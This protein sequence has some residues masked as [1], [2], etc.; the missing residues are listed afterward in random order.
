MTDKQLRKAKELKKQI[1][2]CD[3]ILSFEVNK[4]VWLC[5]NEFSFMK[6]EI[7]DAVKN[8]KAELQAEFDNL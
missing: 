8:K 7:F 5:D 1:Q 3:N 2:T 4:C 6:K